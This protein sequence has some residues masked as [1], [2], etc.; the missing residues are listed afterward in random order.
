MKTWITMAALLA[1]PALAPAAADCT[2]RAGAILAALDAGDWETARADFDERMRDGLGAEQ[3]RQVWTAL[4]AQVGP[5]LAQ[6][7]ARVSSTGVVIPLQHE[8]AWLEL[9]IACAADGR[10]QG[11]FVRPGQAPAAPPAAAAADAKWR[12]RELKVAASPGLELPATLTMPRAEVHAGVV[13]VHGSGAH[14]RDQTIGPNKPFRDLAHGLAD[15]GIAVLRYEKRSHAHPQSFA[16]QA[17]TVKEEVVDDAVA[18]IALLRAQPELADKPV[19]VIGHSLGAMLAPRIATEAQAD[20]MVLMAPP[21]RSLTEMIPQQLAY[22]ANLDGVVDA[23]EQAK[24]DDIGREIA[25][26]RALLAAPDSGDTRPVLGAPPSYWRDLHHA[27][28]FLVARAATMP[29]LV[30]QGE[31]DYQVTMKEDYQAWRTRMRG[32]EGYR[33]HSFAGLGHLFTPASEKPGPADYQVA[34]SM[35]PAVITTIAEWIRDP[36]G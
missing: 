13:L 21:A 5:R 11:L 1:L 30:L 17:F 9:Q 27:Q 18:A 2:A 31:R 14:D 4:P 19:H 3:L 16:D 24:I 7:A 29:M 12:E 10:V 32:R 34:A 28:P 36:A 35:D 22:I 26:V 23:E 6:G 33:E 8:K 20:G 15:R 25:R